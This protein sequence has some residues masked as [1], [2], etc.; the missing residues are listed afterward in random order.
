MKKY[1]SIRTAGLFAAAVVA[2]SSCTKNFD[3]YNTNQGSLSNGQTVAILS[4]A[5]GPL[6][7]N[8]YSNYQTAQN[9][10][11]DGDIRYP[12]KPSALRFCAV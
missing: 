6:E 3:S 4:T 8:V 5:F 11:A 12:A 2:G 1:F 10:N 7:Q 9:L